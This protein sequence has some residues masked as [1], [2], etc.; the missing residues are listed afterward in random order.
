MTV[1]EPLPLHLCI[2]AG[3]AALSE[4][5]ASVTCLKRRPDASLTI[6]TDAEDDSAGQCR[7]HVE[8]KY[9]NPVTIVDTGSAG[10]PFDER[11]DG[12]EAVI[13]FMPAGVTVSYQNGDAELVALQ[14]FAPPGPAAK[15]DRWRPVAR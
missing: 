5:R 15:Y 12:G 6:V 10:A 4:L 11:T 13:I 1:P 9:G 7:S 14:V 3:N 8:R 2:L